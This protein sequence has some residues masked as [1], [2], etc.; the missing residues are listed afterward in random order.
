[1][2]SGKQLEFLQAGQYYNGQALAG[3]KLYSYDAGT[4]TPRALYSD[5]ALTTP[6]SNPA[7]L[8][9]QGRIHAFASGAYKFILK[10]SSDNTL[11]TWDGNYFERNSSFSEDGSGYLVPATTDTYDI[12]TTLK[13]VRDLY[14]QSVKNVTQVISAVSALKLGTTT[15]NQL[16][17]QTNNVIRYIIESATGH[18]TPNADNTYQLGGAA[19]RFSD[20]YSKLYNNV[21]PLAVATA[22]GGAANAYTATVNAAVTGLVAG[23]RLYFQ[24]NHTN[25]G[26]ATMNVNGLGA[27][28][29]RTKRDSSVALGA[30]VFLSG[31]YYALVY[32]G[33][34][35]RCESDDEGLKSSTPTTTGGGTMTVTYNSGSLYYRRV[36]N[37]V[38]YWTDINVTTS[39]SADTV[40]VLTTPENVAATCT[41][42]GSGETNLA[43]VY[44]LR[45]SATQISIRQ[46]NTAVFGIGTFNIRLNGWYE[47]A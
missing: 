16:Q 20:F 27:V 43:A 34:V 18:F 4:L 19:Q 21:P 28:A 15:G 42:V 40:I 13:R 24:A 3:G 7:I 35:W 5:A 30:G 31:G 11:Y 36:G 9:S 6:L 33:T 14:V 29:I 44:A 46:Y 12:G 8:D 37:R 41:A 26:A 10:D 45:L 23:Q 17:L 47:V 32:D 2:A 39:G 25:T 38:H 1:M 22:N